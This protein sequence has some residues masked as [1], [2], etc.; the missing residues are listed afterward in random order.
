MPVNRKSPD[1]QESF[2]RGLDDLRLDFRRLFISSILRRQLAIRICCQDL[3]HALRAERIGWYAALLVLACLFSYRLQQALSDHFVD[4]P[5]F[6]PFIAVDAV[7]YRPTPLAQYVKLFPHTVI[8]LC[9][10]S[11]FREKVNRI[12][13]MPQQLFVVVSWVEPWKVGTQGISPEIP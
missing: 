9:M 6:L 3:R 5:R 13:L 7:K 11:R 1:H 4:D 10:S 2:R 12:I 8:G